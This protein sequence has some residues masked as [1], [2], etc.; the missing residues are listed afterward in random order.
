MP[1]PAAPRELPDHLDGC[2]IDFADP[3]YVTAN[4]EQTDALVMFADC[5]D[6]P[7]E[8]ERRRAELVDWDTATRDR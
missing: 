3:A 5:W 2:E 4:G 8:L 1:D 6:D 7:D